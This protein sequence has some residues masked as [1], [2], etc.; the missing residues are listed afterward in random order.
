MTERL[1]NQRPSILVVED[2]DILCSILS[3]YFKSDD[4][5]VFEAG[6]GHQALQLIKENHERI[7]IVIFDR[8]MPVLSG[9]DMFRQSYRQYPDIHYVM[10]SGTTHDQEIVDLLANGLNA[11]MT[12]PVLR[13]ELL[14]LV[15]E[16][17]G[18]NPS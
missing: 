4:W 12:K 7:G 18:L 6:D 2:D 11:F 1:P 8:R 15:N 10:L 9:S 16:L 17:L 13:D 3:E 14:E 5:H